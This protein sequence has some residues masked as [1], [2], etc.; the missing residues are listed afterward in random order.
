MSRLRNPSEA[1]GSMIIPYLV[2]LVFILLEGLP[3]NFFY[4]G[5]LKIALYFVPLFFI[6]LTAESDATPIFLAGLGLLNDIL[7]EMP[8]GFW[9]SLF[10]VFYLLCM[11][12]RNILSTASFGS[13]W[14]S[15]AV[16]VSMT[17]VLAYLF[18]LMIG[19]LR[20][21]TVPFLLSSLAC[22]LFFPLLYFPLSFFRD[23]VS[24][25]ERS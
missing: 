3:G 25:S 23:T 13:Y 8:L 14:V 21:A 7:S 15:F 22:I 19:E 2:A 1:S 12:Q 6:G 24:A 11:S 20:L 17:Y 10:V 5:Q 16:L 9:S 4:M 18:A